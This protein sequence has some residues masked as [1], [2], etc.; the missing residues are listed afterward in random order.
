MLRFVFVGV[1]AFLVHVGAWAQTPELLLQDEKE[2]FV[3]QGGDKLS[4]RPLRFWVEDVDLGT[5]VPENLWSWEG[6]AQSFEL[7]GGY[8]RVAQFPADILLEAAMAVQD[9]RLRVKGMVRNRAENLGERMLQLRLF[10]PLDSTPVETHSIAG[11]AATYAAAGF[12]SN[13]LAIG[14]GYPLGEFRA[15]MDRISWDEEL[16]AIVFEKDLYLTADSLESPNRAV[17]EFVLFDYEGGK[18]FEGVRSA[19]EGLY[20]SSEDEDP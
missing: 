5:S 7:P 19:Y 2:F 8:V 3:T 11:M 1:I 12:S 20:S 18:G 16:R 4:E 10:V 6:E 17:F 13:E 9:G 14:A 15:G